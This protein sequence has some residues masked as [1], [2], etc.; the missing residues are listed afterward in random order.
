MTPRERVLTSLQHKEPDRVPLFYRDVPEVERRL[1]RDLGLKDRE[2]LLQHF[3]IDFRWVGPEYVGPPLTDESTGRKR[4]IWGIEYK[5]VKFSDESGYWE[6]V[7]PPLADCEDPAALDDYPWPKLEWFD[8]SGLAD[9]VRQCD[10]YAIMTAPNFSSPGLLQT[11]IQFLVGIEKS[12][13]DMVVNPDFL[14]ALI[15]RVLDFNLP[16]IDRLLDAAGGRIDLFR[17][18]DDFGTQRGL[19]FSPEHWRRWVAPAFRQ[20]SDVARKH[21]AFLYLHSCGSV[22]RL[23][24]DFI[25]S[26]VKVLDPLQVKAA[27]MIPAQLKAE[28]G[29]KVCFSGG[30][31]EQELLPNGTPEDVK[32]EV[33]RLLD[34]MA[35][36]GGYFVGPTHNFQDDIPTANIV[37][38]Y[39][40]AR[41]WAY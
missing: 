6:I 11:P 35:P 10:E 23:I 14:Q 40:A 24:P 38:M 36:G 41:E 39:E 32:A 20:L 25:E 15:Q 2:G 28:F 37:A 30:V 3:D 12:M 18:G 31:D 13:M 29:N 22:R 8:F 5:Y 9:A 21:G 33:R 26:G 1:L 27:D 19:L 7:A 17:I 16:F 4:D 34:I